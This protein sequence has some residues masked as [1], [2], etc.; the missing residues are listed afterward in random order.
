MPKFRQSERKF[1]FLDPLNVF[2]PTPVLRS[3]GP[4][5]YNTRG[6]IQQKLSRFS[7]QSRPEVFFIPKTPGVGEYSHMPVFG[8]IYKPRKKIETDPD[9]VWLRQLF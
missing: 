6:K 2:S 3:P 4:A 1:E 7:K 8:K 5:Q 9:Q